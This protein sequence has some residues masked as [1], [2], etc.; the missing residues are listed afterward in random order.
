MDDDRPI[1]VELDYASIGGL[2]HEARQK[3]CRVAPLTLGQAS[4]I[5]GITP[6]DIALLSVWLEGKARKRT[7]NGGLA[8]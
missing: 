6:A 2:R 7:G 8:D 3:F 4:R 5:S 1:P